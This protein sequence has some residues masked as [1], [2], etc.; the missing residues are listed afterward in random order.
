MNQTLTIKEIPISERPYE[1]LETYGAGVLSD[2]ELIAIIIKSGTV[3]ERSTDIAMR[4]IGKHDSGLLGLHH[5]TMDE[6]RE[7]NGIGRVKAIQ[8]KAIAEI[9]KRLS[10]ATQKE[11]IN[12][13]SPSTVASMYMEDLRH[14]KREHLIVVLLDTKHNVIEDYTLSIGTVNASLI[15]PREVFIYALRNEAVNIILLH[16]HPSGNPEPSPQD[17]AITDRI[18]EAGDLVGVTL[19]DHI[20]IGDGTY[21]S[22]KEQGYITRN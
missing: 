21:T 9:S 11:R 14:L 20:I 1:K 15:H 19:L 17:I 8:L 4:I 6:L 2:A 7:I 18:G 10:R 22:L 16:N 12:V 3:K 5:L 13:N